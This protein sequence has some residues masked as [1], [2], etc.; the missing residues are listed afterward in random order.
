MV[1]TSYGLAIEKEEQRT[2]IAFAEDIVISFERASKVAK[3]A[4]EVIYDA[5][6]REAVNW[7]VNSIKDMSICR[8]A[9][10]GDGLSAT[11]T[12][13]GKN[14]KSTKEDCKASR[15]KDVD[16]IITKLCNIAVYKL[17][18]PVVLGGI[19]HD[20]SMNASMSM[21]MSIDR[22]IAK[23]VIDQCST[24]STDDVLECFNR[25]F[26]RGYMIVSMGMI[27]GR[28]DEARIKFISIDR[29]EITNK[30]NSEVIGIVRGII[31][32]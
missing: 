12:S 15:T 8:P 24:I 4:H 18:V 31:G 9:T 29:K 30:D 32:G 2:S 20:K 3:E 5:T 26:E 27:P 17:R 16:S 11:T 21:Y 19:Y 22:Q 28:L 25:L 10:S 6:S 13:I 7:I 1:V 23:I 14:W